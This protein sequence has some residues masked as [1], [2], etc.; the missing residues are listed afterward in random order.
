ML[1]TRP[2]TAAL[3]WSVPI[4]AL[5]TIAS[6]VGLTV[7][8]VY[9]QETVNWTLQA[10]GQDIGNLVAVVVLLASA[11]LHRRGTPRAG[12]IWLGT[13]LYL[14]YAYL[15]YA[16][17][18]HFNG[19][20]LVYVAVLGLSG[21]AIIHCIG[22]LRRTETGFPDGGRRRLAAWTLLGTGVLFALRWLSE[23]VPALAS[24]GAPASLGEAG[25]VV[26]PIHVIDLSMVLPAFIVTGALAVRD[27]AAGLFWLGPWLAFSVLMGSSIV[28]AMVLIATAGFPGTLPPAVMV[29]VIVILSAVALVRYLPRRAR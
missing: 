16:M 23:L 10:K 13:L 26:N 9:A 12:L 24:G 21:Y 6:G 3:A 8:A 7:P 5:V 19:L 11:I 15:V 1:K 20:F 28:A 18:V 25:L 27:R 29:S 14:V 17:A 2:T 4:A 22:G